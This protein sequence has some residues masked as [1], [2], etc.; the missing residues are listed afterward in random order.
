VQGARCLHRHILT[1]IWFHVTVWPVISLRPVTTEPDPTL[2]RS[3]AGDEWNSEQVDAALAT[4]LDSLDDALNYRNWI[5]DLAQPYIEGPLLEVGAGHGTFTEVFVELAE[6]A[7]VEP[8]IHAAGLLSDRFEGD[9]RVTVVNGTVDDVALADRFGS[10][11]MINVLEHIADDSGA[12]E[13]VWDRLQPGGHLVLWV[14]AF[15]LLYSDFDT[16]LGH[17]RR[18]NRRELQ[19]LVE[20]AGF[21]VV[22]SGYV[23]APGWFS[24]LLMVRLLSIEPT[25]PVTVGIFDRLIVPIVRGIERWV[26]PPFGQSVFL[27][28]RKPLC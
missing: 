23:N 17:E 13:S 14:P 19:A 26:R 2:P 10:A 11:V 15:K 18:Y 3:S 27:A 21:T 7:A 25:S 20:R 5:A 4:T 28:A 22:K 9:D 24:W 8:G 12:L 6:V 1:A 16:K